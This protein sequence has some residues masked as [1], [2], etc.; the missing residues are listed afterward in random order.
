MEY[1]TVTEVLK[2]FV[3]FSRI[4]ENVLNLA[5]ARGTLVH[6]VC[7]AHALGV[8][9]LQEVPEEYSGYIESFK[10]WFSLQVVEV[11]LAE[12]RLYHPT[13]KYSG[14]L[15]LIVT[16]KTEGLV[17]VD[18]KTPVA[19]NKIWRWQ[20]AG[21]VDLAW[22]NKYKVKKGG[23]LQLSPEGKPAK[24]VWSADHN[25]DFVFFLSCLNIHREL[26]S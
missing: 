21:Y 8:P 2:L 23:T 10:R 22:A 26:G 12:K 18:L 14:K 24:M 16:M 3:D 9:W 13:Y 25:R 4:P 15:D 20:I 11:V 7:C 19:L 6:G 1:P 5:A 17:L